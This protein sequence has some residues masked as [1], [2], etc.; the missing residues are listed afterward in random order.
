[1][2]LIGKI[3][4]YN[5]ILLYFSAKLKNVRKEQCDYL[6]IIVIPMPTIESFIVNFKVLGVFFKTYIV[7][8]HIKRDHFQFHNRVL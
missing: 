7:V 1:M 5:S 4:D 8:G 2:A 3:K 6:H